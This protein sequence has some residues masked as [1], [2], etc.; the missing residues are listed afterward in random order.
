MASQAAGHRD[1]SALHS[2]LKNTV[3]RSFSLPALQKHNDTSMSMSR[4]VFAKLFNGSPPP[5]PSDARLQIA[6]QGVVQ[7]GEQKVRRQQ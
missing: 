7:P 5:V 1:S 3:V 2:K 6:I 4:A